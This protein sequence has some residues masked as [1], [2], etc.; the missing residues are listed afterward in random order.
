MTNRCFNIAPVANRRIQAS[1]RLWRK[2]LSD[3]FGVSIPVPNVFLLRSRKEFDAV[4]H[5][6]KSSPRWMVGHA[7]GRSIFILDPQAYTKH[8]DHT[9]PA[10]FWLTL[11]HEYVHIA[12]R[13]FCGHNRPKWLSEGLACALAGQIKTAPSKSVLLTLPRYW[14]TE[15]SH[16]YQVGTFWTKLL[17]EKRGKKRLLVFLRSVNFFTPATEYQAAFKKFAGVPCTRAGLS[18]LLNV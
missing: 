2:E 13:N 3:F 9:D 14:N 11:K 17:L 16:L 15:D 6:E 12:M 18:S 7:D 4:A 8:S 10:K 5:P 1:L